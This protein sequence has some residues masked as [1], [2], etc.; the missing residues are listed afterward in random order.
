MPTIVKGHGGRIDDQ[1][2]FVPKG[3]TVKFYTGFDVDLSTSVALVAIA[4]GASAP[5]QETIVGTGTTD[6]VANYGLY[7]QDDGFIAKWL[8][9]GGENGIPITWIGTDIP[10]GTRLCD[11]PDTC[12]GLG[13]H[14]CN[15]VLGRVHDTEIIILACRGYAGSNPT[16][17]PAPDRRYGTD[18]DDPLQDITK[19]LDAYVIKLLDDVVKDPDAAE[20]QVDDLPQGT[21][22]LLDNYPRFYNWQKARYLKDM[23]VAG[24]FTQ[25]IGHLTANSQDLDG[26]MKWLDDIPSYGSTVDQALLDDAQRLVMETQNAPGPVKAALRKRPLVNAALVAG[27][28]QPDDAALDRI[29]AKN[30]ENLKAAADGSA[31][32]VSTGGLLTLVGDGHS[33]EAQVYVRRQGDLE[34]GRVTITKGGAFSKGGLSV[35]GISAKRGLV[36]QALNAVSDKKVAFA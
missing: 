16:A 22:A 11:N 13:E 20:K 33:G 24:D 35:S 10:D 19:D 18:E 25:L 34:S 17:A 1:W 21:I 12:N 23:A 30:G 31:I 15:G 27:D 28:W 4:A 26:I 3:T 9:M 7:T 14:T 36:E 2:T 29:T 6:D 5:A 8:A 32:A